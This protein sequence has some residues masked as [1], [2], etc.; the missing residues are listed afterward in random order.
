LVG[1]YGLRISPISF[2]G[3]EQELLPDNIRKRRRILASAEKQRIAFGNLVEMIIGQK[4]AAERVRQ[5]G[6]WTSIMEGKKSSFLWAE[7]QRFWV[8]RGPQLY[9]NFY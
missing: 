5:L 9:I 6:R 2:W 7:G 8:I 1:V 3:P 4:D